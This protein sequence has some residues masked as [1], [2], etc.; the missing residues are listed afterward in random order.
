MLD[1]INTWKRSAMG[2]IGLAGLVAAMVIEPVDINLRFVGITISL[3]LITLA[4][5]P[6]VWANCRHWWEE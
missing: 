2:W 6:R 3:A 4:L 1:W 5:P